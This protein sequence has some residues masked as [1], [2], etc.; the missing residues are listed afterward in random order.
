MTVGAE[1]AAPPARELFGRRASKDGRLVV[2]LRGL[3]AAGECVIEV[4]VFPVTGLGL[5]PLSL[6]PHR[7]PTLDE[8][9]GFVEEGLLALEYLGCSIQSGLEERRLEAVPDLT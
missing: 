3:E 8:A 7:F 1:G 2:A 6:G 5:E 4:E 9:V